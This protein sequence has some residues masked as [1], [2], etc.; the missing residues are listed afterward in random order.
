MAAVDEIADIATL[1]LY[2]LQT[3]APRKNREEE[4]QRREPRADGEIQRLSLLFSP[5]RIDPLNSCISARGVR[6]M[7][8]IPRAITFDIHDK[9]LSRGDGVPLLKPRAARDLSLSFR[10]RS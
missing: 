4:L 9:S 5:E 8:D 6:V 3:T 1:L 7:P 10:S 2:S